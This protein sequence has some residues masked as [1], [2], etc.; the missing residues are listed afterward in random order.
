MGASNYEKRV[1]TISRRYLARSLYYY[2]QPIAHLIS[3]T[4]LLNWCRVLIQMLN[5][6][7]I[8]CILRFNGMAVLER[9]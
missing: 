4:R 3:R 1:V 8:C 7:K 6:Y 9:E 2:K 5:A